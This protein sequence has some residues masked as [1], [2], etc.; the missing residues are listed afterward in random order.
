MWEDELVAEVAR[1]AGAADLATLRRRHVEL[2]LRLAGGNVSAAARVLG[3]PR[4]TLQ[5]WRRRWTLR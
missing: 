2:V 5:R 1:I 4:Q 3:V